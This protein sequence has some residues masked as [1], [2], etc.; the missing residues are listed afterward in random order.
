MLSQ[1]PS[2]PPGFLDMLMA[3]I[4]QVLRAPASLF[5]LLGWMVMAYVLEIWPDF[6]SKWIPVVT[7]IGSGVSYPL[8]CPT[9]S[10]TMDAP[11]KVCVLMVNGLVCGV[12]AASLHRYFLKWLIL[13][14]G[15]N[16]EPNPVNPKDE[17]KP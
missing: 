11:C 16:P 8:F 5:V 12:L 3:Q 6:P 4:N 2:I 17:N 15:I 10:V 14:L 1:A 7:I 9:A 13:K